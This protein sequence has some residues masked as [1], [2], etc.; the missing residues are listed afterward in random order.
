MLFYIIE[1]HYYY[2]YGCHLFYFYCCCLFLWS[3]IKSQL[4]SKL[5]VI[6]LKEKYVEKNTVSV[7][8]LHFFRDLTNALDINRRENHYSFKKFHVLMMMVESTV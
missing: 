1:Y 5:S 6:F 4:F 3:K 2:Y 7:F 8:N